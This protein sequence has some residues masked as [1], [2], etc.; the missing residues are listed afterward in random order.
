MSDEDDADERP[1]AIEVAKQG[2]AVFANPFSPGKMKAW[3]HVS[4]LF[5]LF[6]RQRQTTKR[7]E[8]PDDIDG[9]DL[10]DDEEK[11][12]ILEKITECDAAFHAKF[13]TKPNNSP[14]KTNPTK[15][16]S[17]K[18][19]KD[20]KGTDN[21]EETLSITSLSSS[22][23][24]KNGTDGAGFKD[25]IVLW[26]RLLLPGV[27]KRVYNLQSKQ[28]IKLFSR[29]FVT[30]QNDMLEHL[31]LGDIGETI[32]KFFE[33]SIK[34]KPAKKSTLT[35][36]EV[37]SF[38]SNLTKLTREEDQMEHFQKIV[39]K[40][41]SNDIKTIIRLIKGDLRMGAG[42]KHILDGVHPDA[43]EVYQASRDIQAVIT[44]CLCKRD[45]GKKINKTV[46]AEISVM[47]PVLPML[48]E[49]Y[50]I[51]KAFPYA[52]DL[53]LDSEILMVDTNT[54]K[55]LPFGTLGVHK[56]AEFKDAT[57]CLFVFDCIY[58]NGESLIDKPITYRKKILKENMIEIS[59]H[60]VF[61]EVE[62]IRKPKELAEMIA[63]VLKLGLEGLVLKD[64]KSTYEPG[65]RHWLKVKKDYLFD[66]AMADTADLIVLGAWYGT[67]KK[68]G[69]MSVFL[70]GCYNPNTKKFCT[71]TKVHTGHDDKTLEQ[72]Q[73]ELDMVKISQDSS[74][75][76]SWLNCTKMM[77]PDFVARDPKA[78]PVWE[79]TGAEFT[80][81]DVHTADGI[82][83]RFPR[84]TR[85]R[86]D[87]CWKTATNV[88]E[89]Q[90]L[91][92][93]SKES[94]D[95]SLLTKDIKDVGETSKDDEEPVVKKRKKDVKK[96]K[97]TIQK[98]ES[99]PKQEKRN[100][101]DLFD[102]KEV[103]RDKNE[104]NELD[105]NNTSVKQ[106][107]ANNNYCNDI[108]MEST[109]IEAP[110]PDYFKG[111]QALLEDELHT[112]EH[113]DIIRYFIAY[114]GVVLNADQWKVATHVLHY[115]NIIKEPTIK[116]PLSARHLAIEW[117]KDVVERGVYKTLGVMW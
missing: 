93:S 73:T 58:F 55:P 3:H 27:V 43:Y 13:G 34:T 18:V 52:K 111:I 6:L 11:N 85:I 32:Q 109:E 100:K 57:V 47:T 5:E 46:K 91:Y 71:V 104:E 36:K 10:L 56:K 114:G 14:K 49:A 16:K 88:Q 74:K 87:K 105:L 53:I 115:Y 15:A 31:E 99:S 51:P 106:L 94:T 84:V 107:A 66:G 67:G 50:Y 45:K 78:Q 17:P 95:V 76:P 2:R 8:S 29:I 77:V 19:D 37:D 116:C 54:G 63:K 60:I 103:D 102:S 20:D 24:E 82:S 110:I 112:E 80:Q 38:L 96:E 86:D 70:M 90:Q 12:N 72:L 30:D 108:Q 1:F 75:V 48:A 40:C 113:S 39:P 62:E 92:K 28:L 89:L 25:D 23:S 83:I 42:A 33:E 65:K 97:K 117:V 35:V 69:M 44:K 7:I 101:A 61:S 68:G 81:H 21:N 79:I 4:C 9:W 64:F 98:N 41:T 22:G 59:N 26:C